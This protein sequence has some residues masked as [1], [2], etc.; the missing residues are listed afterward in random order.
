MDFKDKV[1]AVRNIP[2]PLYM[3]E[4]V[5]PKLDG[6][7]GS[8]EGY[9]EYGF[10]EKCPLHNEDTGSF[11][12]YEHTNSCS[13]FGCRR[14]GDIINLHRMFYEI[15]EDI[16]IEF[17][18]AVNYLFKKYVT[19]ENISAAVDSNKK[20]KQ[21]AAKLADGVVEDV[22][23]I[24]KMRTHRKIREA[25]NRLNVLNVNKSVHTPKVRMLILAKKLHRLG[26]VDDAAMDDFTSKI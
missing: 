8:G 17:K 1:E 4:E 16:E 14:G 13:C 26:Y 19:K 22:D 12:Y 10:V 3:K 18:D 20:K 5:V 11:R 2:I 15:N 7:Y 25:E 21:R 6:Y 24:V 23:S 9:F